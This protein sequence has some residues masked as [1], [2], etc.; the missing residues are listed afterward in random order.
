MQAVSG[1]KSTMNPSALFVVERTD[2]LRVFFDVPERYAAYVKP[3]AK[4]AVRADALSGLE[5]PAVVT[6]TSW[7]IRERTR[8]LWTEID[9]TRKQYD[10]LRPG[11]YVT[12]NLFVH[13]PNVFTLPQEALLVQGNQT[14]CYL[15]RDGR[16][17]KTPIDTAVSD[18]KWTEVHKMKIDDPWVNVTGS[19]EVVVGDLSDLSDGQAVRIGPPAANGP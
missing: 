19:E 12:V 2:I 5:I 11:M 18:G 16:A 7:S 1:D 14:Y 13:E 15:V 9:L 6:R 4:A 3:G 8:T 10:G 17:V